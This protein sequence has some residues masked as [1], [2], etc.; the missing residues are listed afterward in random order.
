M[1]LRADAATVVTA[2]SAVTSLAWLRVLGALLHGVA[3][4]CLALM[5]WTLLVPP[6][7]TVSRGAIMPDGTSSLSLA[8]MLGGGA[9]TIDVAMPAVPDARTRAGLRAVRGS[10]RMVR[11]HAPQPLPA[12]AI[13]AEAEWR[14]TGGTRVQVVGGDSTRG[15]LRDGAGSIDS[16]QLDSAGYR[17]RSGPVQGYIGIDAAGVRGAALPLAAS[18]PAEAR[19][20]VTGSATWESRFVVAALEESGWLVD[21]AVSLSPRVTVA[22]GPT[23]IPSRSRHA[24]VIVLAGTPPSVLAALPAFVR[25]GGGVVIVGEAARAGALAAIRAGSPGAT[26]S[27]D[28]GAEASRLPKNGLDLVPVA[29]L[30]AG[31]VVLESRG[32]RPA[33]VA[34]RIGA[35]RVVQV[36]YENS[37]LWRMAG[38]DDAPAAHRRWW[39]A[40]LSGIV[41]LRAP[42]LRAVPPAEHDTLDAAPLASLARDLGL[43]VIIVADVT[44]DTP[45][46]VVASL[47][48]RWLL[49]LSLLTLVASWTLRRWRGLT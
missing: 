39:N 19:V 10:G 17:A 5:L 28:V 7:V 21:V 38:N 25:S 48:L 15:V 47:D 30:A 40:L 37:W 3:I 22:Q 14:A 12:L 34:R 35:G 6:T 27:G 11:L 32:A 29:T 46:S 23:R 33:V 16:L 9:D 1:P 31:S 18:L 13:S 26:I 2:P 44:T 36:G 43:P 24:I 8:S 20:L 41:P 4:I 45:T 49:A 42:V